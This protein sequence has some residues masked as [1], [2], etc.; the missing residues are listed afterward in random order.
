MSQLK[1]L[2]SKLVEAFP[3]DDPSASVPDAGT[4]QTTKVAFDSTVK[5]D[6]ARRRDEIKQLT[7]ELGRAPT[8]E[9]ID[10]VLSLYGDADGDPVVMQGDYGRQGSEPA[11]DDDF[12][13]APR[14][15]TAR[16][17]ATTESVVLKEDTMPR[18]TKPTEMGEIIQNLGMAI[19][20][21]FIDSAS[22]MYAAMFDEEM[23]GDPLKYDETDG[24]VEGAVQQMA[25]MFLDNAR[26][27]H[28]DELAPLWGEYRNDFSEG[29]QEWVIL[30]RRKLNTHTRSII[31]YAAAQEAPTA[32]DLTARPHPRDDDGDE[33]RG[34][35]PA[36]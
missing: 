6:S 21:F 36:A 10:L 15:P 32:E 33:P 4:S 2:A 3:F 26:D 13:I 35:L 7:A 8:E 1:S 16:R 22:D 9:E 11:A 25:E 28:L 18:F 14:G 17:F 24:G 29:V 34:H 23:G 20:P 5:L 19:A 30:N 31:A 27:A 12:A